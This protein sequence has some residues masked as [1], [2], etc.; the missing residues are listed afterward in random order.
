MKKTSIYKFFKFLIL[1][2]TLTGTVIAQTDWQWADHLRHADNT[3]NSY[4]VVPK[5][6]ISVNIDNSANQSES[7]LDML[8]DA[9]FASNGDLGQTSLDSSISL[10]ENRPRLNSNLI[11]LAVAAGALVLVFPNDQSIMDFVQDHQSNVSEVAAFAGEMFGSELPIAVAGA[12]YIIGLVMKNNKIKK[13]SVLL[14]KSLLI[15]GLIAQGLKRAFHRERPGSGN[16][17]YEFGGPSFRGGDLSFPSGHTITAF[18]FATFIAEYTKGKSKII[19]VLAYAAAGLG[20]WS[21]VHDNAHWA[22]DV[23]V[24]ALI[25]H[26]VT[27]MILKKYTKKSGI[28]ISPYMSPSGGMMVGVSYSGK[29]YGPVEDESSDSFLFN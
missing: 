9:D 23:I 24:G 2:L 5:G 14:A 8:I 26:L 13:T 11:K 10:Q 16:G 7:D 25:G 17:P 21:R 18:T 6:D 12:G 22:S 3:L 20:A 19:P 28:S 29:Q 27:K 4:T 15:T 1:S